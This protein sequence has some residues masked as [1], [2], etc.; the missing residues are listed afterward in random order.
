M[1][2]ILIDLCL[3]FTMFAVAVG[4]IPAMLAFAKVVMFLVDWT[5]K[6]ILPG[7]HFDGIL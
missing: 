2:K 7:Y 6:N 3:A 5:D 4:I 1:K